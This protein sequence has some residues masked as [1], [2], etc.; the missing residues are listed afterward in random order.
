MVWNNTGTYTYIGPE[1]KVLTGGTEIKRHGNYSVRRT[2]NKSYNLKLNNAAG[3]DYYDYKEKKYI[4][5]PAHRRW[6]LLAHDG[7]SSRIKTTLGF[8]M[9]RRVLKNM[10]WQPHA[11]WVFFFLNGEYKG[12]YILAEVIKPEAGR[13][14][15]TP[16]ISP[17][18]LDGGFVVELNNTNWYANDVQRDPPG[19]QGNEFLFDDLY[20]FMTGHLNTVYN[21]AGNDGGSGSPKQQG[22]A[23]SVK[24]PDENLGWYYPDPPD[25]DGHLT[26]TN[27]AHAS[28]YPRNG[29]TLHAKLV[30]GTGSAR[31]SRPV[32]EWIVPD[33]FGAPSGR[34]IGTAEMLRNG[35]AG[36]IAGTRTLSDVYPGYQSS[37]FVKMAKFIQ[38]AEDAI[39]AHNWGSG[40]SGGYHNFIDID[41]FIDWQIGIEMSCNWEIGQLNGQYMYYDPRIGKLKMGPIWDI[42]DGWDTRLSRTL[43]KE[44]P[45]WYKE[46]LGINKTFIQISQDCI[47]N[48]TYLATIENR[49]LLCSFYPPFDQ[50]KRTAS[51]RHFRKIR[52]RLEI[53]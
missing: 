34:G 28:F 8:E 5:L 29:I 4:T 40:G 43:V 24:E 33:D 27:P 19:Q 32:A 26:Y 16:L 44:S 53:I 51:Q 22:V 3:F 11:D 42:D 23:F 21:T 1:G 15:I 12:L 10:G 46:L 17:S 47:V 25:G 41:S 18:S 20:S 37:A 52:E 30:D 38:D 45:F 9:G 49:T 35:G 50:I 31:A 36:G 2:G 39:Y 6:G 48:L 14:G 7:D 13:M